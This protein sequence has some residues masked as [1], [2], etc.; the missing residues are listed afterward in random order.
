MCEKNHCVGNTALLGYIGA[1][2]EGK[3][4]QQF[5]HEHQTVLGGLSKEML[6]AL[7]C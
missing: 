1:E 3:S 7:R 5:C 2:Q 4:P 6:E